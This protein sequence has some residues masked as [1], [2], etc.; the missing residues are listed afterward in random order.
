VIQ[1]A[2]YGGRWIGRCCDVVLAPNR[3]VLSERSEGGLVARSFCLSSFE[4]SPGICGASYW[5]PRS[6]TPKS[7]SRRSSGQ[8]GRRGAARRPQGGG[9]KRSEF[10]LGGRANVQRAFKRNHR[11][12]WKET[13]VGGK[14]SA[15]WG[16][17]HR[18][19]RVSPTGQEAFRP[20]FEKRKPNW[21]AQL[22]EEESA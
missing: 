4:D 9:S 22:N 6:S 5:G 11:S 15:K 8:S 3:Q 1:G 16:G 20:S 12:F 2:A 18:V 10:H 7:P 19:G 21:V 14:S 17:D 13:R